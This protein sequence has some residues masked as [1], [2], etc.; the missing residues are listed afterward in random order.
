LTEPAG[1]LVRVVRVRR[2][3]LKPSEFQ[4]RPGEVGL[5]LFEYCDDPG[6]ARLIQAVR[7]AG[8]QGELATAV[9]PTR[10]IRELGLVVVPTPGGTPDVEV[11]MLHREARV[12]WTVRLWL[13]LHR[14]PLHEYFNERFALALCESARLEE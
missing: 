9:I 4:L 7:E 3:A 2:G 5:S 1:E 11:N 14:R 6:P 8:K 13:W 10:R 12:R